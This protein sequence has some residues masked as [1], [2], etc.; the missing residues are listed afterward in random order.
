MSFINPDNDY[1]ESDSAPTGDWQHIVGVR[2]AVGNLYIYVDGVL[3]TDT[4]LKSG[5]IDSSGKLYLGCDL[6]QN[7]KF[8]GI[9]DDVRIYNRALLETEVEQLY[10]EGLS[11]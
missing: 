5:A 11:L 2:D 9:I 6:G 4:G 3:Q 10:Q 1:V 7:Y 8:D